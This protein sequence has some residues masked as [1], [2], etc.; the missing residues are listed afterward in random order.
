MGTHPIFESDFD[1]LTDFTMSAINYSKWDKIEISDDEDDTHPNI[2]T[3]SL[4]KWRHEARVQRMK[5]M[6]IDKER[7]SEGKKETEAALNRAKSQGVS[8]KQLE[9]QLSDW[10]LKEKELMKKEKEQPLNV[11]TIGQEAWST[12]RV[13]TVTKSAEI[14]KSED[15]IMSDYQKFVE[16]YDADI[17]K[18]GFFSKMKDSEQFLIDNTHL[19]CEHTASRL[20]IFSID[21]QVEQKIELMERVSH[22]AIILQFIL[23]LAKSIKVDP[24]GCF[25]QFFVK[26]SQNDN[27]D[28]NAAFNDELKSFR[29]RV[30]ERAEVRIQNILEEQEKEEKAKRIEESPGG[31]DPQEV[32]ESLPESWQACFEAK[33]IPMLQQ[34]VSEMEP[35]D[36]KYHLDR[37][38]KSGLWCPGGNEEE[39]D[40]QD[41]YEDAKE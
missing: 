22:Q 14:K 20:C 11:D 32:F 18:F 26:F 21:L 38:I 19:V 23:E 34:A 24:R 27:P 29:G 2:H 25:R 17:K 33:D 15:E 36:A 41:V 35:E 28:Y 7:V 39:S 1:C 30:K 6:E 8:T 13:N 3:P 37:C 31:L 12:S 10:K 40:D 4:F 5:E 9:Q 16:K